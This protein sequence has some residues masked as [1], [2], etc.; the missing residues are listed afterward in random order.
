[1]A[2]KFITLERELLQA[3]LDETDSAYKA[4]RLAQERSNQNVT[5]STFIRRCREFGIYKTNM[6]LKGCKKPNPKARIP[7]EK[8]FSGE[9][10]MTGGAIK[11]KLLEAGLVKDE[12]SECKLPP[13]WNG[14]KLTIQLDHIDGD[15]T[16]NAQ[17]NLRLL[18]PNCHSQTHTF[19]KGQFRKKPHARVGER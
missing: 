11:R 16:N 13:V 3:C 9:H 5:Y 8:I 7:L 1:M 15:R 17:S 10:F 6:G 2:R 4:F 14:K 12:C 19:S 18:C